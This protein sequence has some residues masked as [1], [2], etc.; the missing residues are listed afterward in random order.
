MPKFIGL[1]LHI[2]YSLTALPQYEQMHIEQ[3]YCK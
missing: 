2:S 1:H 3:I